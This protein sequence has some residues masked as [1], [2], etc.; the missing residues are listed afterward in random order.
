MENKKTIAA[1]NRIRDLSKKDKLLW[2]A[3]ADGKTFYTSVNDYKVYI[4][5]SVGT[6]SFQLFNS[7]NIE[8]GSLEFG[9]YSPDTEGLDT[10]Y[11]QIRK[12][13][14]NIDDGLDDLLDSL[15]KID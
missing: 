11:E 14:L 12:K 1:F 10:F 4:G 8:I 3:E 2:K 13:V 7:Q 15:D 6:I 9:G 5:E